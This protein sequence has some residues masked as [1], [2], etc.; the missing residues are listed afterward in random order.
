MNLVMQFRKV[1]NHPEIF[2][3][4]MVTSSFKFTSF[5]NTLTQYYESPLK[6]PIPYLLYREGGV[7]AAALYSCCQ[8]CSASL[9]SSTTGLSL[10][11][12]AFMQ[13]RLLLRKFSVFAPSYIRQSL[14]GQIRVS[15]LQ[16]TPQPVRECSS[17][18]SFIPFIGASVEEVSQ[19][20]AHEMMIQRWFRWLKVQVR[21]LSFQSLI[22]T[23][24]V[25]GV[26]RMGIYITYAFLER[27]K[28]NFY[29]SPLYH[30]WVV[31]QGNAP[32]LGALFLIDNTWDE[33]SS[34]ELILYFQLLFLFT[35]HRER[36]SISGLHM[37]TRTG[38][39]WVMM[40]SPAILLAAYW[41]DA[42]SSFGT[43]SEPSCNP[44]LRGVI[45]D[46]SFLLLPPLRLYRWVLLLEP[47]RTRTGPTSSD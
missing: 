44:S 11:P 39:C 30:Y 45:F 21:H 2:E 16:S 6:F 17:I 14:E 27:K 5:R 38:F 15:R 29:S 7:A 31:G 13:S 10:P 1:C 18:F 12:R 28:E 24:I 19:M 43:G 4:R 33:F 46:P 22:I 25:Y 47:Q 32:F 35:A 36:W 41:I 37:T 20:T 40:I 3:R 9:T 23:E 34:K 8:Q 42:L 26:L